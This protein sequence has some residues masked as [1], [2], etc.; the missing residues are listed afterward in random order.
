MYPVEINIFGEG[1]SPEMSYVSGANGWEKQVN[2]YDH[3]GSLRATVDVTTPTP[4]VTQVYD[5]L[6]FGEIFYKSDW[7]RQTTLQGFVGLQ[8]DKESN[9]ADH[10]VRKYSASLGRFTSIDPLWES[11]R[12]WNCPF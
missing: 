12:G 9:L 5:Y 10:G 8:F 3:L 6:P 4:A 1:D 2:V 7:D 11:Y